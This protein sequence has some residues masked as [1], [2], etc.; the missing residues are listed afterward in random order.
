LKYLID[1][2]W[3]ADYLAGKQAAVDLVQRREPGGMGISIITFGEIYEGIYYGRDPDRTEAGF[4]NFLSDAGV[5]AL[6]L[7]TMRRFAYIRGRLRQDGRIIGDSD[8]LVAA[9]A[10]QNNLTLVTRNTR[11]FERVP[12]LVIY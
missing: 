11:H 5:L 8:I 12:G 4:L 7:P 10:L 3:V 6:D 9:T 1:S 2:D